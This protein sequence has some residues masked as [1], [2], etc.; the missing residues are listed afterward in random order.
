[1]K[2]RS[3]KLVDDI[4]CGVSAVKSLPQMGVDTMD[5]VAVVPK[6]VPRRSVAGIQRSSEIFQYLIFIKIIHLGYVVLE[7]DHRRDKKQVSRENQRGTGN[8]DGCVG[9]HVYSK[10]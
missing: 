4:Q 3:L 5:Y 7:S 1:M 2:T 9:L 6:R 10:I 8:E